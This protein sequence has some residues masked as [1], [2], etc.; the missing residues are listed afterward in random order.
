MNGDGRGWCGSPSRIPIGHAGPGQRLRKDGRFPRRPWALA[1]PGQ[2]VRRHVPLAAPDS[3]EVN[4]FRASDADRP[5][6]PPISLQR[7][8]KAVR[9]HVGPSTLRRRLQMELGGRHGQGLA[10]EAS[11]HRTLRLRQSSHAHA[12]RAGAA[13]HRPAARK[14]RLRTE[15][16]EPCPHCLCSARETP[17]G[18]RLESPAALGATNRTVRSAPPPCALR[19]HR[20]PELRDGAVP[21][22][23]LRW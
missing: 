9:R 23:P 14:D 10:A 4:L 21:R 18:R 20:L 6:V 5:P 11:R 19:M 16:V 3:L 7:A 13:R 17:R 12:P 1:L 8:H 2:P 15:N 22:S